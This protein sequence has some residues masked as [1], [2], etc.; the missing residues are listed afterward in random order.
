MSAESAPVGERVAHLGGGGQRLDHG[1][2]APAVGPVDE[3][4]ADDAAEHPGE[5]LTGV[6]LGVVLLAVDDAS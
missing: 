4:L 5:Q 2:A 1:D 6:L 3:S